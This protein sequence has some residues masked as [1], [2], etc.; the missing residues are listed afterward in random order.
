MVIAWCLVDTNVLLRMT[1]RS[2]PQHQVVAAALARPGGT[3]H[4]AVLY[5][6]EHCGTVEYDD[7]P[8]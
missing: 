3:R 4:G 6:P 7:A 5:A 1:R 2:D 8:C